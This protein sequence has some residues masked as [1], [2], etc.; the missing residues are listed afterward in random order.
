MP[1]TVLTL[2]K[3]TDDL[4]QLLNDVEAARLD[5]EALAQQD[6]GDVVLED[7]TNT[8]APSALVLRDK[9]Q[10]AKSGAEAARDEAEQAAN[11]ISAVGGVDGTVETTSD[12]P[13]S[14]GSGDFFYVVNDA[15]YYQD[16]GSGSVAGGWEQTGPNFAGKDRTNTWTED[17]TFANVNVQQRH[18]RTH[19]VGPDGRFSSLQDAYANLSAGP[20]DR[21]RLILTADTEETDT[22]RAAPHIDII[23]Q[24]FA[25]RWSN[26][27]GS[28]FGFRLGS[29]DTRIQNITF[30]LRP[31]DAPGTAH[32]LRFT[33]D[34]P[35]HDHTC[36]LHDVTAIG[37]SPAGGKT[38]AARFRHSSKPRCNNCLFIS[39]QATNGSD[40]VQMKHG[41]AGIFNNCEFWAIGDAG[42]AAVIEHGTSPIFN[43][44][45]FYYGESE[46]TGG[47]VL[48]KGNGAPIL[49][50][51]FGGGPLYSAQTGAK[52]TSSW[53]ATGT[54]AMGSKTEDILGRTNFQARFLGLSLNVVSTAAGAT[55]DLG[56]SQGGGEIVSNLDIGSVDR[57]IPAVNH[58][59][60]QPGDTL[61]FEPSDSS[62]ECTVRYTMRFQRPANRGLQ[63][64]G[65]TE[66]RILGGTYIGGPNDG[67]PDSWAAEFPT[68]GPENYEVDGATF[69]AHQDYDQ[70]IGSG[71]DTDSGKPSPIKNC[72][73]RN[74]AGGPKFY[75]I[76]PVD[77]AD[78]GGVAPTVWKGYPMPLYQMEKR[79]DDGSATFTNRGVELRN[80]GG[81][82]GGE[83]RTVVWDDITRFE[84]SQQGRV[85]VNIANVDIADDSLARMF[86]GIV[87]DPTVQPFNVSNGIFAW[88]GGSG[89]ARLHARNDGNQTRD[90]IQSADNAWATGVEEIE[91]AWY[92]DII[93]AWVQSSG[94]RNGTAVDKTNV[95]RVEDLY[96]VVAALDERSTGQSKCD[97]DVRG[98]EVGRLELATIKDRR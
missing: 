97:F 45:Q 58:V 96:L 64:I 30:D 55:L 61:Y 44:C 56:T 91:I 74:T 93:Q 36:H 21:Q 12:L 29:F 51:C 60:L 18:T 57:Y 48:I 46:F 53:E 10:M 88:Q 83:N 39:G 33:G 4:V 1:S 52:G 89:L 69:I 62:V 25:A 16:T 35:G 54:Q 11:D 92:S 72:T 26:I 85:L 28:S 42:W 19:F 95:P 7:G 65:R 5:A 2:L 67:G 14:T 66:A 13:S 81:P 9:A 59:R 49:R 98:V 38:S 6:S 3:K 40:A 73:F 87:E 22:I 34:D 80:P 43:D 70:V 71:D 41:S 94:A 68:D 23:G 37:S 17:N 84:P 27:S 79:A 15:T 86:V 32:M 50:D 78:G 90:A 20:S 75:K 63:L 77:K 76:H 82:N 31:A 24:G 8:N 47:A